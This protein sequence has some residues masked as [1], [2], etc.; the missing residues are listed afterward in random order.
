MQYFPLQVTAA[1]I[2][3][4]MVQGDYF[5]YESASTG[6]DTRIVV[7]PQN[8]GEMLLKPGQRFRIVDPV[9][10]WSVRAFDGAST[11]VGVVVIG[12][13]EFEDSNVNTLLSLSSATITNTTANRV[14][15][16][17]DP[18]QTLPVSLTGQSVSIAG[19][20]NVAGASVTYTHSFIDT[21]VG[22]V[23]AVAVFTAA[24]NL[25][26]TWIEFAEI[27]VINQGANTVSVSLIAKATAPASETDGDV[28]MICGVGGVIAGTTNGNHVHV[29]DKLGVRLY[30]AAGK[31]LYI[32]QTGTGGNVC[33]KTILT[34]R[35]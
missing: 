17:L 3:N 2:A 19:T 11:I 12:S 1:Q 28:V 15:V 14:P 32:N 21:T 7:K 31:G 25:N 24:Q 13:G 27:S 30:V 35:L 5:V 6:V 8:G 18:A 9:G 22:A 10:V 33:K 23:T 29:N 16:T 20:V 34:T 4:L 26:G